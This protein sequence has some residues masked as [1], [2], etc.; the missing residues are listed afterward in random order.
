MG[1]ALG[2]YLEC[3]GVWVWGSAGVVMYLTSFSD[4]ID[5]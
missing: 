1:G 3:F 4:H 5:S 2:W